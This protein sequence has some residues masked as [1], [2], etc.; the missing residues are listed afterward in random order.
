MAAYPPPI[1]HVILISV[2]A[3][4]TRDE[5]GTYVAMLYFMSN[6]I[7]KEPLDFHLIS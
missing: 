4:T 2:T 5:I 7:I 6:G 3:F 1:R